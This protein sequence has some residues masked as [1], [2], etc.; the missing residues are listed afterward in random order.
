MR[1]RFTRILMIGLFLALLP[2]QSV[3]AAGTQQEDV[4]RIAKSYIGVPYK[5]GGTTPSGFDC[6][7]FILFVF[8]KVGINLPRVSADQYNAGTKVSKADLQPGDLVFFEKTYNKAGITHSGVYIG[9]NEFISATSSKGIKI[10][11]L[12]STYWGPKYYGATRVITGSPSGEFN[13]VY[14]SSPSYTAIATLTKQG[15][16]Q[17]FG[18]G[19]FRPDANV[20]RGQAAAIINR[21]LNKQPASLNYFSDVPETNRFAKDIAV[22]KELGIIDGFPDGTFR[23]ND[24]MTKAQMAVIVERAFN[25]Q[26]KAFAAA[27]SHPYSDVGPDYWAHDAIVTM[28]KIDTT[29]V[30]AGD[31]Y[32]ATSQ[33]SRSI[34]T[35]AIY[36][37]MNVK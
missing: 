33:A 36:N 15:V 3:S 32:Y 30:F 26:D 4:I 12:S 24:N 17:G 19:T 28:S 6:S 34:Y 16:I 22:I 14:T 20:T 37:A 35:T 13:D 1:Q 11:S 8:E 27:S 18:D 31:R 10:D 29:T 7:G 25:L 23:P 9:N 21:V 5:Y 2:F